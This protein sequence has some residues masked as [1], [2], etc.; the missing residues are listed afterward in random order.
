MAKRGMQAAQI[1][2]ASNIWYDVSVGVLEALVEYLKEK[3]KLSYAEI[4]RMLHRDQR[5]IWTVYSRVRKKR[6]AQRM[7]VKLPRAQFRIPTSIWHDER[8]SVLEALVVYLKEQK[9]MNYHAIGELLNRDERNIWTIYDRARKK[10]RS[11]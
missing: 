1:M 8:L 11:E 3:E 2:I 5:N 4:G 6:V 7:E 9:N 10:R